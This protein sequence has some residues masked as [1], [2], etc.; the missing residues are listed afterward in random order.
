[1]RPSIAC[2]IGLIPTGVA[3]ETGVSTADLTF[4]LAGET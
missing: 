3:T 2:Y 4:L 1:M